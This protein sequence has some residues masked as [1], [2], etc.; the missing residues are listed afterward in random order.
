MAVAAEPIAILFAEQEEEGGEI[1]VNGLSNAPTHIL[2]TCAHS[3][4]FMSRE[5]ERKR[6]GRR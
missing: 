5:Q 2:E 6:E 1:V 4:A 3:D